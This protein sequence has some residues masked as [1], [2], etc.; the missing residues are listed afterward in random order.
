MADPDDGDTVV[1]KSEQLTT[2]E[3][4]RTS[5][6]A[7]APRI[8]RYEVG[9]SIGRGGM[10]EVFLARDRVLGRDVA[11]KR[12]LDDAPAAQLEARFVR[13]ARVQSKLDHPAIP[14]VYELATDDGGR[15]FIVMKRLAGTVLSDVLATPRAAFPRERLLRGFI[16]VCLAIEYAHERGVI[17]RDVKPANIMLGD[18]GEV[19]VLDWGVAKLVED[20]DVELGGIV[21]EDGETQVGAVVGT[22]AYMSPEQRDGKPDGCSDV[23]ALGCVLFEILAGRAFYKRGDTGDR[24]PS[25]A[26]PDRE[27]PPELD[28]LCADA[29]APQRDARTASAR[30]LADRVQRYL[31]GDRDLAVRK[32]LARAHLGVAVDKL[33]ERD[34]TSRAAALREAGR[35]LALDPSLVEAA[36]IVHR[37]TVEPPVAIPPVVE[38]RVID[39]A[40]RRAAEHGRRVIAVNCVHFVAAAI[41]LAIGVHDVSYIVAYVIVAAVLV[42]IAYFGWR[43]WLSWNVRRTVVILG[44]AVIVALFSQIVSPFIFTP[45]I[46]MLVVFI[47]L[48]SPAFHGRWAVFLVTAQTLALLVPLALELAG[49]IAP[50]VAITG[51]DIVLHGRVLVMRE[52]PVIITL[53]VTTVAVPIFTAMLALGHETARLAHER[54]LHLQAWRLEQLVPRA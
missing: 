35:A 39:A 18:F 50:S 26:A 47:G 34:E 51:N 52:A 5:G 43:E 25:R 6:R 44:N 2:A 33:A 7:S 13:E 12:L 15:P 24:R 31:D 48:R 42:M 37:V 53:V 46:S 19:Y 14:P 54:L 4:R 22:P 17:H 32:E 27:I 38:A 10:G 16:G 41:M 40:M 36:D 49:V 8:T 20:S 23:Y 3:G 11:I 30:E 45:T 29:T 1:P 28:R 21:R 9:D